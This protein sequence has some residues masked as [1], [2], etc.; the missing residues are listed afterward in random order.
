MEENSKIDLRQMEQRPRHLALEKWVHNLPDLEKDD[1]VDVISSFIMKMIKKALNFNKLDNLEIE[2]KIGRF[3]TT[4]NEWEWISESILSTPHMLILPFPHPKDNKSG[5]KAYGKQNLFKFE[6][7]ISKEHFYY[8]KWKLDT[9]VEKGELRMSESQTQD[10]FYE[11]Q[12]RETINL[13][14]HDK[15]IPSSTEERSTSNGHIDSAKLYIKKMEREDLNIRNKERDFRISGC[16]E[17]QRRKVQGSVK[18]SRQKHRFTYAYE[19]MVFE[20]TKVR[21]TS[22]SHTIYEIELEIKDIQFLRGFLQQYESFRKLIKRFVLNILS[23]ANL[24]QYQYLMDF[25]QFIQL[26]YQKRFGDV[27]PIIGGYLAHDAF[28]DFLRSDDK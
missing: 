21:Q 1:R 8:L 9:L 18:Y 15:P 5:A 26:F 16:F 7:G 14:A 2:A 3:F 20:L 12:I 28:L 6:P 23:L 19:F 4:P 25:H 24:L 27:Q 22:V 10:N 13:S 11:G 17:E